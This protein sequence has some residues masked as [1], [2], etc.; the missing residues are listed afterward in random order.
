MLKF[1]DLN[2]FLSFLTNV[3]IIYVI[4]LVFAVVFSLSLHE[5]SHAF[6]ANFFG[7]DTAKR[8]G[9][10]TPNPLKHLSLLGT[11]CILIFGFG[12]AR[13][14]PVDMNKFKN[15]K[16]N[17]ALVALAGPCAN[18]ILAFLGFILYKVAV[19]FSN[20]GYFGYR[21]FIFSFLKNFFMYLVVLNI[22]LF[23]FNL[24]PIPPLD[25]S[26]VVMCF[27]P[28]SVYYTI[29]R[30]EMF[31]SFVIMFLL[32]TGSLRSFV[33]KIVLVLLKFIG[34]YGAY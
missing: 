32:Y 30:N 33:S 14:V 6:V 17:M 13:P 8:F 19:I 24:V 22:G 31:G 29:I 21:Y 12:W 9:R 25:G 16:K 27:L 34:V 20:F 10:L 1:F 15:P 28:E 11:V 3:R 23:V 5:F 7:D 2:Y 4:S 18:F 26:R